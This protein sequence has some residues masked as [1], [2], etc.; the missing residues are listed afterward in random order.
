M[1]CSLVAVTRPLKRKSISINILHGTNLS[2]LERLKLAARVQ[3]LEAESGVCRRDFPVS[4]V[5]I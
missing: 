5:C 1:K 3:T 2:A 4:D